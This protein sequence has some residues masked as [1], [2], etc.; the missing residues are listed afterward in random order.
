MERLSTSNVTQIFRR[1]GI[2]R[3]KRSW[4]IER[5]RRA[6][7][8]VIRDL[9]VKDEAYQRILGWAKSSF[10]FPIRLCGGV[11]RTLFL[12]GRPFLSLLPAGLTVPPGS[13]R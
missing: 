11:L 10:A 9:P 3:K 12:R 13:I 7:R 2:R 5:Y 4:D 1:H 8:L 6:K